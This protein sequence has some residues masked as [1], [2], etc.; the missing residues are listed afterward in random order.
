MSVRASF[1]TFLIILLATVATS[2]GENTTGQRVPNP[3][4]LVSQPNSAIEAESGDKAYT[5]WEFQLEVSAL[6]HEPAEKSLDEFK[7]TLFF[8]ALMPHDSNQVEKW[9]GYGTMT[10]KVIRRASDSDQAAHRPLPQFHLQANTFW[11]R[12]GKALQVNLAAKDAVTYSLK[13]G[14]VLGTTSILQHILPEA[15][16][17]K[18]IGNLQTFA[19][20]TTAK[21]GARFHCTFDTMGKHVCWYEGSA[22]LKVVGKRD[23]FLPLQKEAKTSESGP[24]P[25][26]TL[27]SVAEQDAD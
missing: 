21:P 9:S 18:L 16:G 26:D 14:E 22:T 19:I 4:P 1:L 13:S 6:Q 5:L 7:A 24:K 15:R 17:P 10:S 3:N 23:G 2:A 20:P 25:A 12:I 27:A 8:N 11:D